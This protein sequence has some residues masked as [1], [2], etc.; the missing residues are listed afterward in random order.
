MTTVTPFVEVLF[1]VPLEIAKGLASGDM[2]R[3]GGVVQWAG[4]ATKGEVVAWLRESGGLARGTS[5]LP[6]PVLGQL[7]SLQMATSALAVGQAITLGFSV[8]SFA[9]LNHKLNVL[10]RKLD[11]LLASLAELKQEVAWLD[12]RQDIALAARLRGALDQGNW[13]CGSGR[14]EALVGVRAV[15]VEVEHHYAGLLEGML[16]S[17]R[18]HDHAELFGTYQGYLALAAVA[19]TRCEVSL[20]GAEAGVPSIRSAQTLLLAIDTGFREPLRNVGAYPEMLRLGVGAERSL[21]PALEAM[22]ETAQRVDGYQTELSYCAL[23][24]IA[25]SD[26]E[27]LGGDDADGRL[28]LVLPRAERR[29]T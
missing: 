7:Q 12:R 29:T 15:L 23:K 21:R 19:R 27:Q 20:D 14:L 25:M 3:R 10:G 4:G 26:W 13:A 1:E 9:V 5:A 6:A 22:K 17:R 2:I 18:A 8:L 28:A 16:E 11:D 24:G